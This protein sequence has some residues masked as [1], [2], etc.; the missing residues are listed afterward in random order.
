[1][2]KGLRFA[3]I[4]TPNVAAPVQ[5]LRLSSGDRYGLVVALTIRDARSTLRLD[6]GRDVP[7]AVHAQ[8]ASNFDVFVAVFPADRVA[9]GLRLEASPGEWFC[10]FG[11][12]GEF[13]T[14]ECENF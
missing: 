7:N 8:E 4:R 12:D 6:T 3:C 1:M 2:Y 9:D 14:V 5:L 10:D 13:P 11:L